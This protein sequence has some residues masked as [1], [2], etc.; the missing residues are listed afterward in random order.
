MFMGP[1]EASLPW[2]DS[3]LD[4][5]RKYLDR[6]Y[7]LFTVDEYVSK[8]T[9]KN[10]TKLDFIYHSTVKKVTEDFENLQFNTAISALMIL[11][12]E[13]YKAESLYI[14]Y[15]EGFVKM[16]SCISP[17][18]GEELWSILGHKDV[19]VYENWPSF[20]ESKLTQDMVKIAVSVN[21]KLRGT[22]EVKRDSDDEIVK[23]KALSLENVIKQI[24]GKEIRKIIVVKNRIV[25][26]VV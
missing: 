14:P 8:F 19:I 24:E 17:F 10:D 3:G 11:T 13:F 7:R 16:L 1:L 12:N 20:D 23:N 18:I 26:I 4:G 9:M 6:V 2:N 21:G 25:N 5:A 15:L 22:L